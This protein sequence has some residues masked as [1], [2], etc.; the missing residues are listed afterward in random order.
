MQIDNILRL[1]QNKLFTYLLKS[2][3]E[4]REKKHVFFVKK[5]YILIVGEAPTMLVAHLDTVHKQ[6][7][8]TICRSDDGNILMSPQGIGG[9]D[10]CGVYALLKV[11]REARVKPWLL[12]TCDEEIGG[13]GA[14]HFCKDFR[15]NLLPDE[16]KNLKIIVEIDRKGKTDAVYYD[17]DCPE[18]E[19]YIATKGYKTEFGTFSDISI[20]APELGIA[21]VNL[22]S[23]YYNAHTPHEFIVLSE[24]NN[25]IAKVLEIVKEST[26]NDFPVYQYKEYKRI[27]HGFY[28]GN[29][30]KDNWH[31]SM[32]ANP[33]S[34]SST[35]YT[36]PEDL[37]RDRANKYEMLLDIYCVE[38]LEKY[39][40]A[41]G[42]D[43]IDYI[44]EEEFG[45][46]EFDNTKCADSNM[47][48]EKLSIDET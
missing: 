4:L 40:L 30:W 46:T 44:Y 26:S 2:F 31:N 34:V 32:F 5:S 10:R 48:G 28:G 24:T 18:L 17:C 42:D 9:D 23:G 11:Y 20:I 16:L 33:Y 41:Y 47:Y 14:E 13:F 36:P 1:T 39:R 27:I 19:K 43:I 15:D 45:D 22:S 29:T 38:D 25:T 7:V 3:K 12:F 8:Q 6:P 37:P 35:S 21:G